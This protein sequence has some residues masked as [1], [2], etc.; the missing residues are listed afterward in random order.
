MFEKLKVL[1]EQGKLTSAGLAL[2][3]KK[4]WITE[5]ERILIMEETK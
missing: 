5:S 3:V 1:Y 4:G 2:A